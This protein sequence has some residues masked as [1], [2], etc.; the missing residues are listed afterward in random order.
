MVR[1]QSQRERG[2]QGP[3][4]KGKG[5]GKGKSKTPQEERKWEFAMKMRDICRHGGHGTKGWA[6]WQM[7]GWIE[8]KS[9][10]QLPVMQALRA[11]I[12]DIH[13]EI[14]KHIDDKTRL[15][16]RLRGGV[17]WNVRYQQGWSSGSRISPWTVYPAATE[18]PRVLMHGTFM[19]NLPRIMPDGLACG[20]DLKFIQNAMG[21]RPTRRE[22]V[23]MVAD[24]NEGEQTSL[25]RGADAL[26]KIDSARVQALGIKI[27]LT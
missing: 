17:T 15:E 19:R 6:A 7:G 25:R 20:E 5:G 3:A 9:I 8:W 21:V 24:F 11:T 18:V 22:H 1:Q 23:H 27:M 14:A 16:V 12:E 10:V 4:P 26:I 13:T 2:R